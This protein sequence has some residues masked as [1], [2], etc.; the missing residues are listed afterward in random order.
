MFR[1]FSV[2]NH[3]DN[4]N[5][6]EQTP[7][8]KRAQVARACAWCRINRVRCDNHQQCRNC[9]RRKQ[10]CRRDKAETLTLPLALK[11]VIKSTRDFTN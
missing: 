8:P 11:Y 10:T 3:D 1:S 2:Y 6:S 4:V 5:Q 9:Q 7:K